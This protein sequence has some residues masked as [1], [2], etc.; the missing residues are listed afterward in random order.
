[1]KPLNAD[2]K[3]FELDELAH[4]SLADLQSL[5]ESVP[6]EDQAYLIRVFEREANKRQIIEDIDEAR[7]AQYFLEQYQQIGF[8]P[9][10]DVWLKIPPN[11]QEQYKRPLSTPID[12]ADAL[13]TPTSGTPTFPRWLLL[14][15]VPFACLMIFTVMRMASGGANSDAVALVATI[16]P[17]PTP[18]ATPTNTPTPPPATVTPF[19]LSGFDDAIV[20]GQRASR[21]YYPV[22]LQIF[23][24]RTSQ[25][26]VFIV[27]GQ[28]IGVAEWGFDNNPDIVSWLSGMVVKP[29]LGVPFSQANLELFRDLDD[30]AVFAVTMNTGNVLQFVYASTEQVTRTDTSHFRQDAPG[31]VLVLMNERFS[32]GT[33]TDLRYL[34]QAQ[35][36]ADQELPALTQQSTVLVPMQAAQDLGDVSLTIT[37][38]RL[39]ETSALPPELA[40]L[41]LDIQ[42]VTGE[43]AMPTS[44]LI[45]QL[46][47]VG[48]RFAPDTNASQAGGCAPLE[49]VLNAN[50]A[51]CASVGFITSRYLDE[52]RLFVGTSPD[53]LTPFALEITPL[54]AEPTVNDLDLQLGRIYVTGDALNVNARIFNPTHTPITISASDFALVLGFVPNPTGN[55]IRTFFETTTLAPQTALDVTLSFAYEGEGFAQLT[56][57]GRVWSVD[58]G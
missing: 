8:V 32:D 13:E 7:M 54:I 39:V 48:E 36:P 25:P 14:L 29:V 28:E 47:V 6:T 24:N 27:Q 17:S 43:N 22:Q 11:M 18:S 21:R 55:P 49:T 57:L 10:G 30:E 58:M 4:M 23:P 9:A 40:Y 31:L 5:W 56:L 46:D 42:L 1:M 45:W 26:R 19:A 41:V 12:D 52:V 53:D 51:T 50:S 35:Y 3:F 20:S 44:S 2:T 16:T 33:P 37:S 15:A 34:V 38:A